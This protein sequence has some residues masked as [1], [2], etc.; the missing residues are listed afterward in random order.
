MKKILFLADASSIHTQKMADLFSDH[1]YY[2]E[3]VS[4]LPAESSK[5]NVH[6]IESKA[7]NKRKSNLEY[8]RFGVLIDSVKY[9]RKIINR[10]KPDFVHAHF[11]SSYGLF[12]ALS[13]F[14]PLI[15]SIWGYD[16]IIFPK[17]SNLNRIILKFVFHRADKIFATS[18]FLCKESR[19]YTT[20]SITR[21]PFGVDIEK[22]NCKKNDSENFIVGITK[23]LRLL[24]GYKYLIEAIEIVKK[25][26]PEIELQIIGE[27]E[28]REKIEKIIEQKNMENKVKLFGRIPHEK[29][30]KYICNFDVAVFPSIEYESFG[31]SVLE[32]AASGVPSIVSDIGGLP[33]VIEDNK[34]GFLVPPKNAK[35][36]AK[37]ILLLYNDRELR[38]E[39]SKNAVNFVKENYNWL[40]NSNIILNEYEKFKQKS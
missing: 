18:E 25:D 8:N 34:T 36:I 1:G 27:G 20:K 33:E 37:K 17:L 23:G 5:H 22:F 15:V 3:I 16:A 6:I 2:V 38:W 9:C 30:E 12:G 7:Y 19:I 24:Y 40:D 26:I 35:E 29:I 4:L 31:V 13:G 32:V 14:K 11:A 21:T 10:F 39:M 28:D